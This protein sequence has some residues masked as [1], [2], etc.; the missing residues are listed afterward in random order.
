[1]P[2]M[3]TDP[4]REPPVPMTSV[5]PEPTVVAT[6]PATAPFNVTVLSPGPLTAKVPTPLTAPAN[7]VAVAAVGR[8]TEKI[9]PPA[10]SMAAPAPLAP[11]KPATVWLKSTSRSVP[12]A[13]ER[14]VV[15]GKALATPTRSVPA[16]TVVS[17]E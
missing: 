11:K 7:E 9:V 17:P 13:R 2:E 10:T 4:E 14:L 8:A 12:D 3:T 1:M 15:V 6:V 16:L 5:V